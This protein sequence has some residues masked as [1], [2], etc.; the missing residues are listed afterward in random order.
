M[1]GVGRYIQI[2][3]LQEGQPLD[4]ARIGRL[5][6]QKVIWL[7]PIRDIADIDDQHLITDMLPVSNV[8]IYNLHL[9]T[10]GSS[11]TINM[12][13]KQCRLISIF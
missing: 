3:C 5:F 2:P 10:V 9:E 11:G 6:S 7:L 1:L 4:A 12:I 8:F 13:M